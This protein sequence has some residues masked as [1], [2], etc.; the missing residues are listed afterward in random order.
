MVL[1][2][3]RYR[4]VSRDAVRYRSYF[5]R[6]PLIAPNCPGLLIGSFKG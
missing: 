3:P 4:S 2:T 1:P 5:P 6:P